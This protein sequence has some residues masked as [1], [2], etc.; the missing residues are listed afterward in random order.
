MPRTASR[1]RFIKSAAALT[2]LATLRPRILSAD[3]TPRIAIAFPALPPQLG[4]LERLNLARDAGF[5]GV[6]MLT[7]DN[8]REAEQVRLAATRLDLAIHSVVNDPQ[9]RFPLSS[10]DPHVVDQ[11]VA[12][13]ETSLRNARFWGAESVSIT[14]TASGPGTSYQ[15][16][17]NRS[18]EVIRERVLP[19]ATDA[20]VTLAI[21]DVWD[22]FVVGPLEVARYVDAFESRWVKAC[23]DTS[24]TVF[25]ASHRDFIRVLGSRVVKVRTRSVGTLGDIDDVSFWGWVTAETL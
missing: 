7:I 23:V 19:L 8:P 11:A 1:R 24:R 13:I 14:P 21:E 22:G 18:Q 6:E 17:W 12:G 5:S 3:A 9:R 15:D 16:A 25:Y 4:L 20:A 10:A 2:A